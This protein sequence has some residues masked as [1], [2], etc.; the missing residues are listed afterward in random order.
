[1]R[2]TLTTR[3]DC[4]IETVWT[5]VHR[6]ELLQHI[7][8]PLIRFTYRD[9][10]MPPVRWTQGRYRV[11]MWSFGI[12]PLGQ[13]WVGIEYP[14]GTSVTN[15]RAV[16]RDNGSGTLIHK[17]DHW[18]FLEDVGGGQTRYTDR[19]DVEA[20]VLTPFVWLFARIFY[21]HRQRRWRAL[22]AT[23]FTALASE[24]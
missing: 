22:V 20:G 5:Q 14:E 2:M 8:W 15:G 3:L 24:E 9:D 23:G 17:W 4:P 6:P 19:L 7:A 21:G 1:M 13:Q 12:I 11:G 10:G 16:L 18:I